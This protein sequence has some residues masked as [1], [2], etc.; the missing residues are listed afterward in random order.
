[1]LMLR[2]SV[3]PL[4]EDSKFDGEESEDDT[5]IVFQIGTIDEKVNTAE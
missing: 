3:G 1:M 5:L 2:L 4:Q